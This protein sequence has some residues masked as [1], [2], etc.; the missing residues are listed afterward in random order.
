MTQ[1]FSIKSFDD[2]TAVDV[3]H[4]LK[5]RLQV[6]V[7]EQQC[8]YQDLD[9]KDFDCWHL[10][11][12]RD[13]ALMGYCRILP[14]AQSSRLP[15]L[16]LLPRIGRVLVLPEHRGRGLARE[17]M[18]EAIS[19]CHKNFGKKP[20]EISAQTYLIDFYS[21]LGFMAQGERY[22]EDGLEHITMVLMPVKK[23]KKSQGL[24]MQLLVFLLLALAI[25]F[26][27]GLIYLMI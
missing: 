5:A 14:P 2:L 25:A 10:V 22:F 7:V 19:Y 26:I 20:I 24:G 8:P 6:F 4:I 23:V 16:G 15:E 21:S 13:E 18:I 11:A 27:V 9:D 1:Q 12:H 17:V 3:Y